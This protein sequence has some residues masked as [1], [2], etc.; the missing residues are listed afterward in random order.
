[1]ADAGLADI[2]LSFPLVGAAKAA[3]LAELMGRVT[4][5]VI[6]DS[7]VGV[8]AAGRRARTPRPG[9]I[10]WWSST[11]ASA[12]PASSYRGGRRP[13]CVVAG[14]DLIF[15][16]LMTYPTALESGQWRGDAR[17]AWTDGLT[18]DRVSGGGRLQ[19]GG[20]TRS[21]R[22]TR[23]A[24]D[25]RVWRSSVNR[26]RLRAGRRLFAPRAGDR[27]EPADSR[28]RHPRLGHQDA[29]VRSAWGPGWAHRRVSGGEDL[30]A[31]GGARLR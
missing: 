21:A 22:L 11:R 10:S 28:P 13:R 17:G 24:R 8:G 18:V 1:M 6:A 19:A 15:A 25:V 7:A 23:T 2:L 12:V 26:Q 3:R 20:P 5:S 31:V 29:V 27:R 9:W 4:M 30:W 16:G 14:D